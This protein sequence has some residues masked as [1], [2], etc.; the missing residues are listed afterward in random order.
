LHRLL[1]TDPSNHSAAEA[2]EHVLSLVAALSRHDRITRGHSERVWGYARLLGIELNLSQDDADRLQWVALL[3]DVGKLAVAPEILNK[4]GR[5]TA[6][7]WA[8]I[9]KHPAAG[10]ALVAPLAEWLGPWADA[11]A[12]H[13]ERFDGAGYPNRLESTD[14]CLGAR[15]VAVIDTYD[16]ITSARSYKRPVTSRQ[17]R[18]ELLRCAGSQFDPDIVDAFVN[19]TT[20]RIRYAAGP[21]AGIAQLPLISSVA[22]TGA[23]VS[24]AAAA[25]ALPAATAAAMSGLLAVAPGAAAAAAPAAPGPR[26]T[27]SAATTAVAALPPNVYFGSNAAAAAARPPRLMS[28]RAATTTI[29]PPVDGSAPAAHRSG[30]AAGSS[31]A[32][33]RGGGGPA[34]ATTAAV[35]VR[36]G[37]PSRKSKGAP[38]SAPIQFAIAVPATVA[39]T[40][41][42]LAKNPTP[43]TQGNKTTPPGQ[44]KTR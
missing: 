6:A 44:A 32:H 16:V 2:A 30:P 23:S 8:E 36:V 31:S 40:P 25:G 43:P 27:P 21:L 19:I 37:V 17:A 4:R 38:E 7:E 42:G 11:V 35:D 18:A 14:I 9:R 5:L 29:D 24:A 12:Q 34:S 20:G 41:P 39:V 22:Q 26:P 10:A 33:S 13:H 3:H 28:S 15:I 1:A